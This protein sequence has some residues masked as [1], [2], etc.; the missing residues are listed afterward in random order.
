MMMM[1]VI[2]SK[3][4]YIRNWIN[5]LD[6]SE[7]PSVIKIKTVV[8]DMFE[9]PDKHTCLSK[10]DIDDIFKKWSYGSTGGAYGFNK[11][12]IRCIKENMFVE[13]HNCP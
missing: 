7:H 13:D 2:P 3:P 12:T 6:E 11:C 9:N 5:S 10:S 1:K 4:Q 8:L